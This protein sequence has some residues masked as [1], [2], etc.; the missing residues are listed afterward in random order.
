MAWTHH[1]LNQKPW[2]PMNF[3][4][5]M[6]AW[7]AEQDKAEAT[8]AKEKAQAEFDAEQEYL[9]TLSYLSAEEQQRYR[10]VQS[11]SF[12]YTKPPGLDA[13]L[14]RDAEV[15]KKKS[16]Q[17]QQQ[18]QQQL[19]GRASTANAAN[20]G[21]GGGGGGG[22][23]ALGRPDGPG[24]SSGRDA[25]PQ[26][27]RSAIVERLRE[28]PFAAMLAAREALH[29]NPRLVVSRRQQ[30]REA[31]VFG[32][33]TADNPNQQLLGEEPGMSGQGMDAELE[34]L[35]QLPPDQQLKALKR[36]SKR[37]KKEEQERKLREA[38]AVLRAA[39]YDLSGMAAIAGGSGSGGAKHSGSEHKKKRSKSIKG[40]KHKDGGKSRKAKRRRDSDSPSSSPSG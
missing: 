20:A 40:H 36:I 34:L 30:Q 28:D 10:E 31:G 25:D 23:G 4:N 5:R 22:G 8:K 26:Q 15:E 24:G 18:Q 3:K 37:R 6:R 16:S 29:N 35:M 12:M 13:A 39:G 14:A 21:G 32:G 7:E 27:E 19:Q 1:F 17:Q 9:K 38:E 11:V 33:L 2:H